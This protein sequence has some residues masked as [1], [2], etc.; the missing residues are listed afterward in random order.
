MNILRSSLGVC[1]S[2]VDEFLSS[3]RRGEECSC[4]MDEGIALGY[5]QN[6]RGILTIGYA[7]RFFFFFFFPFYCDPLSIEV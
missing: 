7:D 1:E 4:V 5:T 3:G 2:N 6:A